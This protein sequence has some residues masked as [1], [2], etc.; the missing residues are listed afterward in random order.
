MVQYHAIASGI[1]VP[2]GVKMYASPWRLG[3]RGHV[4]RCQPPGVRLLP[5]G[6]HV[7]VSGRVLAQG[8]VGM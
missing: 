3:E 6:D 5:T 7:C 1:I 8:M 4:T 2:G